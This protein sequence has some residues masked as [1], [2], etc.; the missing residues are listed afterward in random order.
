MAQIYGSVTGLKQLY[1]LNTH[2]AFIRLKSSLD[3]MTNLNTRHGEMLVT[4]CI[5]AILRSQDTSIREMIKF[6]SFFL[7]AC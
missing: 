1:T 6:L 7:C 2:S 5:S 4:K 3:I